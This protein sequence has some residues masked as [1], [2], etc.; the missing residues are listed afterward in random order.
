MSISRSNGAGP[1]G[2]GIAQSVFARLRAGYPALSEAEQRVA[3]AFER[4]AA[5]LVHLPLTSLAARIGV[6]EA[7]II[8][9]CQSIGYRGLR[10]FKL[11]LAAETLA[12]HRVIHEAILPDDSDAAVVD[13][14]LRSDMQAIADT[15][16]VLDVGAISRAADALVAATRIECYSV[17]SSIPIALDAYYRFLRL[18]L[19][20]GIVMDPHMQAVSAAHLPP[21]AIAFAVSHGGRS[22]ETRT[23]MEEARDAGATCILLTSFHH[24][25]MESLAHIQIVTAPIDGALRPEP[26][27]SRIAHLCVIDALTT[28][29]ALRRPTASRAALVQ[30]DAIIARRVIEE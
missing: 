3:V 1:W 27:A 23:A 29:V 12:P 4:D 15:L 22:I 18:G 30:D 6:S 5:A 11:A 20:V 9:C 8:R 14:V 21:G 2:V 19:P 28:V 25:P 24:T 26:V 17:G 16:A 10:D 7:T 13:K